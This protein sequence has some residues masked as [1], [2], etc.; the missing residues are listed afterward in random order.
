LSVDMPYST[1]ADLPA[2]L[3]KRLPRHAQDIYR[4]AFNDAFARYG[5]DREAIAHRIA[6]AAVKRRY[7]QLSAGVWTPRK[8][9]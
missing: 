6:W 2:T 5:A 3:R 8:A 1:N 4:A 9:S 7:V